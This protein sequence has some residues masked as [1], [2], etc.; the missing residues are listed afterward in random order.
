MTTQTE[1]PRSHQERLAR[2]ILS[3]FAKVQRHEDVEF[4]VVQQWTTRLRILSRSDDWAVRFEVAVLDPTNEH[5]DMQRGN[6]AVDVSGPDRVRKMATVN[7][8]ATGSQIAASALAFANAVELAAKVAAAIDNMEQTDE[9][10]ICPDNNGGPH[11]GSPCETCERINLPV[12][13]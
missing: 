9:W 2:S 8:P 12:R 1:R 6:V 11:L 5:G 4:V 3:Q 10:G 7:W 13:A